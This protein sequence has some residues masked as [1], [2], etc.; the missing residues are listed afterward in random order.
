[1]LPWRI[2]LV[3][4]ATWVCI[5]SCSCQVGTGLFLIAWAQNLH[6][7]MDVSWSR[8]ADSLAQIRTAAALQWQA[9][10]GQLWVKLCKG[11]CFLLIRILMHGMDRSGRGSK[12]RIPPVRMTDRLPFCKRGVL[13]RMDRG[14]RGSRYRRPSGR[15]TGC[16]PAHGKG[17]GG[18]MACLFMR[19]EANG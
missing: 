10:R 9:L 19:R 13:I 8:F 14:L 5:R 12:Y 6:S 11:P 4:R 2:G 15:M 17:V 3:W 1:M 16:L 18:L 7:P